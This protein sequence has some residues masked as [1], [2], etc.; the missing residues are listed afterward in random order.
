MSMIGTNV[1]ALSAANYINQSNSE[2]GKS[3]LRL[4]SGSR[5]AIPSDDAGSVAVSGNLTARS[6]R[7]SAASQGAQSIVSLAQTVDGFLSTIQ[8]QLTRLSELAQEASNG[9]FSSS[10]RANYQAEFSTL[11]AQVNLIATNATFD[12]ISLFTASTVSV[13]IN[14]GG[15]TDSL[16]LNTVATAASL[17][18][19]STSI[20]TVTAATDAIPVLN[21]AISC[22]TS[23]RAAVNADV[24]K[25]NFYSTNIS[26]ENANVTS[27]NSAISDVDIA[28]E[29]TK[30]S[31]STIRAQIGLSVLAQANSSQKSVLGLLTS[32]SSSSSA[33][34]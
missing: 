20:S 5:L 27:A 4:A 1:A 14:A 19:S 31:Q 32:S 7:L 23:R 17:G 11:V 2:A 26:Y 24:T 13:A 33:F 15:G 34:A 10:D 28:S 8:N 3:I 6:A 18:L 9:S 21:A 25:F 16:V 22:I 30:L 29:S 12:G